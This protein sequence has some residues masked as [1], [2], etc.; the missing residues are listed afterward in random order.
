M[1]LSFSFFL[2][3]QFCKTA[4]IESFRTDLSGKT[5]II[6]GGN[7]GLGLEC[8]RYI[9]QMMGRGS[10]A[11]R[12]IIACR[13]VEKGANALI[14]APSLL[15]ICGS[16]RQ[17]IILSTAIRETTGYAGGEVWHV[18]LAKFDTISAF[19]DRFQKEGPG[20]LDLLIECSGI[21]TR[22]YKKTKDGWES[23]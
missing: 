2:Q 12:L 23:T 13:N 9:A 19:A 17:L 15:A 10:R 5:I 3:Q 4:T 20:H 16:Y 22:K 7:S 11:G 14:C 18:D 1:K 8:A 6:T 21:G